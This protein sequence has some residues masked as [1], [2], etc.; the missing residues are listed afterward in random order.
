M[1][2]MQQY[3]QLNVK[4]YIAL[5]HLVLD[6]TMFVTRATI[7]ELLND[8]QTMLRDSDKRLRSPTKDT[9]TEPHYNSQDSN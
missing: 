5:Q 1:F 7:F 9:K 3:T 6:L 4:L 8:D 2:P